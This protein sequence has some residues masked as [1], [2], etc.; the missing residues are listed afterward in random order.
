[1]K[2]SRVTPIKKTL[3]AL[4][5]EE[6]QHIAALDKNC[7]ALKLA[8][9]D[10]VLALEQ[11]KHEI[12]KAIGQAQEAFTQ[13]VLVAASEHGID[14]DDKTQKWTFDTAQATFTRTS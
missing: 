9:A 11:K 3:V 8:L 4:S 7:A 13:R 1:M 2:P 12:M 14:T 10:T 6:R 5:D